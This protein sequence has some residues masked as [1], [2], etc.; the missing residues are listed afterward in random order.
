MTTGVRV[1]WQDVVNR[2]T[3]QD[4]D[5][6]KQKFAL[7]GYSQGAVVMHYAAKSI[8][9]ALFPKIVALVMYGDP[10]TGP[11]QGPA[12]VPEFPAALQTKLLMNC[13]EGDRVSYPFTLLYVLKSDSDVCLNRSAIRVGNVSF[14]ILPTSDSHGWTRLSILLAWHSRERLFLPSSLVLVP[15][16][17]TKM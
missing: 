13:A 9:E 2:L 3:Q 8:P 5:C 17:T 4:K 14:R 1:G 11:P 7:V 16:P 12:A 10:I 15:E 6:P